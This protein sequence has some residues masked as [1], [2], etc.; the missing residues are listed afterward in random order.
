ML[1]QSSIN[2]FGVAA[3]TGSAASTNIEGLVYVSMNAIYQ[4]CMAFTGQNLGAGNTKRVVKVQRTCAVVVFCVGLITGALAVVFG[5]Q[6]L[7]LY[8]A[9]SSVSTSVSS[10]IIIQY[11]M[12]RLM[13]IAMTYFFS[14]LMEVFVGGLRGMGV[15]FLPMIVSVVGVCGVRIIWIFTVFSLIS[16]TLDCLYISYPVSWALTAL[17]LFAC[18]LVERKRRLKNL[19][20]SSAAESGS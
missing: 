10:E 15:S 17:I 8:T 11:G 9:A 19:R 2:S 7:T 6:L 4:T 20:P 1:I 18:L 3:M 13:I 14:G 12:Q 16:R 5:R